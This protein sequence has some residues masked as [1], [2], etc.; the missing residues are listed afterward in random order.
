M[1]YR[2]RYISAQSSKQATIIFIKTHNGHVDVFVYMI[3]LHWDDTKGA[4][5]IRRLSN[6]YLYKFESA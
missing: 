4:D 1:F 6:F 2:V 5:L 3:K